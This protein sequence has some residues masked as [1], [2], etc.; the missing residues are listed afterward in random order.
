MRDNFREWVDIDLDPTDAL[1]AVPK[2]INRSESFQKALRD[3]EY[4]YGV[5]LSLPLSNIAE[6]GY[7]H[8]SK[9]RSALL[10]RSQHA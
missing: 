6:R 7:Y 3:Q 2:T 9:A 1:V 5:G 4:A 10:R 8:A